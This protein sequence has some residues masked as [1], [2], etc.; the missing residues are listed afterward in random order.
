[1]I[2]RPPRST[3][4]PYTT[5]FRSGE[6]KCCDEGRGGVHFHDSSSRDVAGPAVGDHRSRLRQIFST[7]WASETP[8]LAMTPAAS[9]AR[10]SGLRIGF[11]RASSR[12]AGLREHTPQ[13]FI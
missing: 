11:M 6:E 5:L 12:S 2:R 1:M 7:Y 10:T 8:S 4:F 13:G 3:L 9:K